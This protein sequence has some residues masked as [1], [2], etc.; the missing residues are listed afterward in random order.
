MKQFITISFL[1]FF[2]SVLNF[3]QNTFNVGA[4]FVLSFPTGD[5]NQYVKTTGG[6]SLNT[7]YQFS[8]KI[9]VTLAGYYF[10]YNSELPRIA[11]DGKTYDFSLE[12]IPVIAGV[13]YYFNQSTF[14]TFE[15]GVN[16]MRITADVYLG[17]NLSTEYKSK[18]STGVGLGYRVKLADASVFEITGAYQYVQDN[19]ST[20][21]LRAAIMVLLGKL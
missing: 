5:L 8:D 6:W 19:L 4:S 17:E 16:F 20:F 11:L 15:A 14:G 21:A 2:I 13:R 3:P 9:S 12:S 18:Y 1:V 10:S 7:E